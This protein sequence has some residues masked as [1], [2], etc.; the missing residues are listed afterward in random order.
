M[1]PIV[2]RKFQAS[3]GFSVQLFERARITPTSRPFKEEVVGDVG[4]VLWVLTGTIGI[5]L[6]I[7]CANVA[8]LLLVRAFVA[9][10][11]VQPGFVRPTEVQ[12]VSVSIPEAQ[13]REPEKTL[14]MQTICWTGL[15][16]YRAF[17]RLR[18]RLAFPWTRMPVSIR[19]LRGIGSTEKGKFRRSGAWYLP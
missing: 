19:S 14:R 15:H 11:H 12:T 9:L 7:A 18:L 16:K 3:P 2:N 5:V 13:V 1:L 8:N 6:L 17:V 4:S 10:T